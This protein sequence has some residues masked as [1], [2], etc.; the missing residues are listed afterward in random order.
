M[1]VGFIVEVVANKL[2][3]VWSGCAWIRVTRPRAGLGRG[4]YYRNEGEGSEND[5]ERALHIRRLWVASV[6]NYSGLIQLRTW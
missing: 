3:T 1:V 6:P 4:E 5:V 2:K